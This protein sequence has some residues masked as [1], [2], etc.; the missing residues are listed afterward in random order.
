MSLKSLVS[1]MVIGAVALASFL[2]YLNVSETEA[3]DTAPQRATPVMVYTVVEKDFPITIEGLGTA[4]ANE[5]VTLTAQDTDVITAINFDDGDVVKAGQLLVQL[6]NT[7][8][9]AN[10]TELQVNLDEATRQLRRIKNLAKESAASEQLLTEQEA[11]VKTLEAQVEVAQSQ[12]DDLQIRAPFSGQL[13]IRQV[14]LGALVQPSTTITTLDDISRVKVDF[15]VAENHLASLAV[16]QK[17]SARS[18]AYP[19]QVFEGRIRTLGSR[20]DPVTRSVLVRAVIDNDSAQLRPGMLLQITLEKQVLKTLV[21]PEKAL[22]PHD[23]KQFVYVVEGDHVV[24]KEVKIGERRPGW[25]QIVSG[26]NA[27]DKVV[28]E[29]TLRVRDLSKVNVLNNEQE[30]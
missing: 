21:L 13:G 7:E 25:V 6:N 3:T 17:V 12:L 23:D 20:I 1:P 4:N 5:S 14:S 10:M 9:L 15:S 11:V 8:E 24:E 2:V 16:G 18:V 27:N 28:T 29:G 26:V 22:V 30:G 19:D